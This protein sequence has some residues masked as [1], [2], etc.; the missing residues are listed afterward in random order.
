[1]NLRIM[2]HELKYHGAQVQAV[3]IMGL[4]INKDQGEEGDG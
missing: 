4:I 2:G 1:M 3:S